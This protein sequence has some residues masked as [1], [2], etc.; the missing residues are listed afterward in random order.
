MVETNIYISLVLNIYLLMEFF[1]GSHHH[2]TLC[3]TDYS[4]TQCAF[5]V[6][7]NKCVNITRQINYNDLQI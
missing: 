3:K 7:P 6:T 4:P 5:D 2:S 1:C